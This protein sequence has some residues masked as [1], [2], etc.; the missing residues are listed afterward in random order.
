[1][2]WNIITL[3]LKS[4]LYTAKPLSLDGSGFRKN[5]F[6]V[7]SGLAKGEWERLFA[8]VDKLPQKRHSTQYYADS[9][10]NVTRTQNGKTGIIL[11]PEA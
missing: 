11:T 10:V 7:A 8:S 1:L 4:D 5:P 2:G 3:N 9:L 6:W